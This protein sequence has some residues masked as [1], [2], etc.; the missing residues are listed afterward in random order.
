MGTIFCIREHNMYITFFYDDFKNVYIAIERRRKKFNWVDGK[1]LP[2]VKKKL[3]SSAEVK[4]NH[5]HK[6][7]Y[8]HASIYKAFFNFFSLLYPKG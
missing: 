6:L 8:E 5:T 4:N 1:I 3:S 2:T 7:S